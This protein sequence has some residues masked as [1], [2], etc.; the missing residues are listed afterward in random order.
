HRSSQRD[1]HHRHR[2]HDAS[3]LRGRR[4]F[5]ASRRCR[6]AAA[7]K[8]GG[9]CQRTVGRERL[10]QGSEGHRAMNIAALTID[11][12]RKDLLSKTVSAGE[13]AKEAL[14]FAEAGNAKTNAYL[15][16]SAER[17]LD[18]ARRVDARIAV[19]DEIGALAGVPIAVK[20]VIVTRGVRTTC[21]SKL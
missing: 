21:G 9:S 12:I 8:R 7:S 1:R 3:D 5:H 13:L 10:F 15:T 11:Q 20:D 4:G 16:F 17:A 6:A 2:A 18:A 19:G 14:R